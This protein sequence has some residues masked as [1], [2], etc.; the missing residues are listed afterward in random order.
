M[1]RLLAGRSGR[2]LVSVIPLTAAFAVSEWLVVSGTGSFAGLLSFLGV[3]VVSLVA[4]LYPVLLLVASRRNGEYAPDPV[5][6]FFG[7]PVLLALVYLVFLAMLVAHAA[8]IWTDTAE[9]VGAALAAVAMVAIPV[10]LLRSRAFERRVTVE[11]RD[12]RRAGH[13][14]FAILAGERSIPGSVSLE[15]GDRSRQPD[16]PAGAIP[17]FD[18]L[19]RA[20][21]VIGPGGAAA[22][23]RVKAWVHRVTPEGE[24]ESLPATAS[25]RGSGEP[26]NLTLS[27]GEA[28]FPVTGGEAEVEIALREL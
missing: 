18:T 1:T 28:I 23:Q 24:T 7:W 8:V 11:V 22:P 13:A 27:R 12:D 17:S 5:R 3:I 2:F 14:A 20:V 21:F 15:Y 10:A 25:S 16:G 6:A 9:Q 19:R 4:G 26:A